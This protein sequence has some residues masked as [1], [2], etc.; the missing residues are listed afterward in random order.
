MLATPVRPVPTRPGAGL[1]AAVQPGDAR[2]GGTGRTG[3]ESDAELLRAIGGHENFTQRECNA[4]A[5]G[6]GELSCWGIG[7][8]LWRTHR[9]PPP[10]KF[11]PI[12]VK[13]K[14]VGIHRCPVH[15]RLNVT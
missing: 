12:S 6:I 2:L 11:L 15:P 4:L 13:L 14:A 5:Q 7:T 9:P 8:Q 3:I 1:N 10:G